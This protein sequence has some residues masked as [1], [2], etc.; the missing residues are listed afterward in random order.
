MCRA[1]PGPRC[2][3]SGLIRQTRAE[4]HFVDQQAKYN[5]EAN[6]NGGVVSAQ[7]QRAFDNAQHRLDAAN[8][9]WH[10]TPKGMGSIQDKLD[11]EEHRLTNLPQGNPNTVA[12]RE[13]NATKREVSQLTKL[14]AEAV[15]FRKQSYAD[16]KLVNGDVMPGFTKDAERRQSRDESRTR[17]GDISKNAQPLINDAFDGRIAEEKSVALNMK[18]W[19]EE[20]YSR[21]SHWVERGTDTGWGTNG[22]LRPAPGSGTSEGPAV[23]RMVRE[24]T[25]DG[26]VVEGRADI[27]LTKKGNK[28]LVSSTLTVA[29]SFE[30]AS[31]IDVTTQEQ[32]S[33]IAGKRGLNRKTIRD[34]KEFTT[35]AE[36]EK[37]VKSTRNSLN[38][39]FH[40]D[41]AKLGRDGIVGRAKK[42][43]S[44]LQNRGWVVWPRYAEP[45]V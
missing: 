14:H 23:T 41:V 42:P 38:Q 4:S 13:Y 11:I 24:N 44:A 18:Q 21:A 31:P 9:V 36:A 39:T 16:L 43:H 30:D 26:Q 27:H 5:E 6:N 20:D 15:E 8:R 29:S 37:F 40:K 2:S 34:T 19:T 35:K 32:G 25:P 33:L 17:G 28:F 45:E 3:N 10:A 7:R 1:R 22:R 12:R